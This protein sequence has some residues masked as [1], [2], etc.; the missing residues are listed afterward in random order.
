MKN[1]N[2]KK[3]EQLGMSH[4]T[5]ANRLRKSI[6]F[7]LVKETGRN[8]CF[9]CGKEI[10]DVSNLSIEHKVPWL[11]SE[12]PIGLYF[13][14]DNIAFSHLRCNCAASRT[15]KGLRTDHGTRARYDGGCRCDKCKKAKAIA[16]A[17]Y[18]DRMKKRAK[19]SEEGI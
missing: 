7:E 1:G 9:Q 4:G 16:S 2:R 5:A 10:D 15:N 13:D 3:N 12:D 6:M 19:D 14:I 17:D 11:D 8:V 18:L